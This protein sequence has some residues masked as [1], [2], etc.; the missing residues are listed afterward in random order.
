MKR[1]FITGISGYIGGTI[2]VKLREKGYEISGLVRSKE[3]QRMLEERGFETL[4]SDIHDV[5]RY[6][7]AINQSD[8]II[9]ATESDDYAIARNFI[10]NLSGTNKVFIYTS[11]SNILVD[12]EKP[13][14]NDVS[15]NEDIPLDFDS[16][17]GHRLFINRMIQ[18]AALS[19]VH[20]I[21]MVPTMVYGD[22]LLIGKE[23]KQIPLLIDTAR[24]NGFA[25]YLDDGSHAWSNV[26]VEDLADLY[27][28]AI[29]K[30]DAGSIY[31]AA[32]GLATFRE[33]A[34]AIQNGYGFP[35]ES[36][37][38]T[39]EESVQTWGKGMAEVAYGSNCRVATAKARQLLNWNP[40]R[41]SLLEYIRSHAQEN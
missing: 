40:T 38:W 20:S 36:H 9:H 16:S 1:V 28:L 12:P 39:M 27:A 25:S 23:G 30:A 17:N 13:T 29:E 24:K 5:S 6:E 15:F 7:T 4:L 21:V 33:I 32:H 11:G 31:Y 8:I 2:A 10:E 37:S 19:K 3:K 41:P 22:G 14:G 18:R 26:H 34:D 35:G